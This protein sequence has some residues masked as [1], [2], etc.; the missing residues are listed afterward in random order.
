MHFYMAGMFVGLLDSKTV[1]YITH[2]VEFLPAADLILVSYSN[3]VSF[4]C[5][6]Y[7]LNLDGMFPYFLSGSLTYKLLLGDE[8]W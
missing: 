7:E 8:R 6:I 3:L 5:L 4:Q 1:V 2:Q